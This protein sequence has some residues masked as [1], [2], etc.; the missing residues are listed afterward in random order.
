M[1]GAASERNCEDGRAG[2]SRIGWLL[3]DWLVFYFWAFVHLKR[4]I[5]RIILRRSRWYIVTIMM[6]DA[7]GMACNNTMAVGMCSCRFGVDP[8][9]L[10]DV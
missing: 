1:A 8:V 4:E 6:D 7:K 5:P 3:A 10:C 9:R 2:S